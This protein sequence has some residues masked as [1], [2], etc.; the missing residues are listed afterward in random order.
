M[1]FRS[2]RKE[3][4]TRLR[5]LEFRGRPFVV[6]ENPTVWS[7]STREK[8]MECLIETTCDYI[9][10]GRHGR[11]DKVMSRLERRYMFTPDFYTCDNPRQ[12]LEE[13]RDSNDHDLI[14][15]VLENYRDMESMRYRDKITYILGALFV[16]DFEFNFS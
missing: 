1:M 13:H 5:D 12:W 3:V 2:V 6:D 15:F 11:D 8:L 10:W 16:H 4:L 7:E 14:L 9:E